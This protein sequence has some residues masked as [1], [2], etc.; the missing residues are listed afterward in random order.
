MISLIKSQILQ[1]LQNYYLFRN[2]QKKQPMNRKIIK[3]Q[4]LQLFLDSK[5]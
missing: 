5:Y 3:L 1:K 2:Q 4:K